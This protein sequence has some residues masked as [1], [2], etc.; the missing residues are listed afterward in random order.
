[1]SGL[2]GQGRRRSKRRGPYVRVQAFG[3]DAFE[4]G[5]VRELVGSDDDGGIAGE[6][7]VALTLDGAKDLRAEISRAIAAARGRGKA[8]RRPTR[9]RR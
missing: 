8:A 2:A 3:P 9:G 6:I 1:M 5:A 4:G 7:G